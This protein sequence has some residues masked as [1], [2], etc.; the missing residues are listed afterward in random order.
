MSMDRSFLAPFLTSLA[1]IE[2]PKSQL[3]ICE[4]LVEKQYKADPWECSALIVAHHYYDPSRCSIVFNIVLNT[5]I[6]ASTSSS[7]ILGY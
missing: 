5:A 7:H 3:S 2:I 4:K 6:E 1:P